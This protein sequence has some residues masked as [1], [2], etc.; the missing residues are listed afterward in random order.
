MQLSTLPMEELMPILS[1]QLE[2]GGRATLVVT[3]N[4]MYP[5][6]RN[7]ADAVYLIP[8]NRPLKKGD[9]ILYRRENGRYILHRIVTK[10]KNGRFFC[11]GDNQWVQE[12]VTDAQ[13]LALVDGFTRGGRTCPEQ[14]RR[15]RTWV[16]VWVWLRPVRRPILALGKAFGRFRRKLKRRR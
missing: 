14:D 10:P 7:R 4:S 8:V 5:T 6:F 15:Y 16:A 2:T 9:L 11:T 12:A 1:A 13:V 3:G